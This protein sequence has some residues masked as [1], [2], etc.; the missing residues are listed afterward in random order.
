MDLEELLVLSQAEDGDFP[1]VLSDNFGLDLPDPT[2]ALHVIPSWGHSKNNMIRTATLN[3]STYRGVCSD[4]I[5]FYGKIKIQG[6]I[7]EYKDTPGRSTMSSKFGHLYQYTYDWVLQR[8][9]TQ[10]DLD[11]DKKARYKADIR[12]EWAH[13]GDKTQRFD[14]YEDVLNFGIEVFKQRFTGNWQF[15][16]S[17]YSKTKELKF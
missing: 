15:F 7:L 6:V 10:E 13:V 2:P 9:V 11:R 8:R 14:S 5:H 17:D 16:L 3:I 4:A 1:P 12:F